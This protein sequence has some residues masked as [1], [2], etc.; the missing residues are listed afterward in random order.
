MVSQGPH[1]RRLPPGW[2][3]ACHHRRWS[4]LRLRRAPSPAPPAVH[5]ED[6]PTPALDTADA[7]RRCAPCSADSA[8]G[9]DRPR[10]GREDRHPLRAS[11]RGRLRDRSS[12]S[13]RS[14][15]KGAA[16]CCPGR[17]PG[18]RRPP[19]APYA[20]AGD[21]RR[22]CPSPPE[23]NNDAWSS[24]PRTSTAGLRWRPPARSVGHGGQTPPAS[25][26]PPRC[27]A[28][29]GAAASL[30]PFP[31][32]ECFPVACVAGSTEQR[33]CCARYPRR[34]RAVCSRA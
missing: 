23:T 27:E 30:S 25:S 11:P 3:S 22:Q 28:D 26:P 15:R 34:R 19:C 14:A 31:P 4:A 12:R 8:P 17:R 32:R 21:L 18:A 24:N 6:R 20:R 33:R 16:R 9:T 5:N 29:R 2:R 1:C 7:T 10:S 13:P